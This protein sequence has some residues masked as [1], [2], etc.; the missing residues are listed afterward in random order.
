MTN[1]ND[2]NQ[3]YK[4]DLTHIY[5]NW[6]EWD[7]DLLKLKEL[8]AEVPKYEGLISQNSNNFIKFIA[9]EESVARLLDKVYLYPYLQRDLDSTNEKASVKLQEIESIYANYSIASSWIT[10][11]ILTIPEETMKKWIDENSEL[12]PNR[13]P[14][15]EVYRLQEH[16]LTADKEKLLSYFGQYLGVPSD[17]YS[18]LS[19][20]DIK[21]NEIELKDGS[22][23]TVTNGVYSKIVSTNRNQEDR[24]KAFE[25]L[26]NSFNINKNTYASIYKSILQRDFADAQSRNYTSSLQ[27]SLNPKNIPLDVYKTL[28]ES[29]R[30]NTAPLKRYIS[31]RKKALEI[32]DYHYYD[33]SINLIDYK[34]EFSYEEAKKTV[35]DSVKPLGDDY[36][37]GL[38]T[39]L[40]DGWLDVYETPNKRSGAYSL[41]IYDVHPY[42]LLNYN[43]TMD[44]VFTLAHELGH[45]MHSMLS[46]KNQPYPI[47][48][49]TIFVAEVASTFNERL[50]LDNM[51]KNTTDSKEKIALIEQAIGGIVGT[52]YIQTL[53][54]DYEYEAHKIVENGGAITPE[55]LNKIME[56]LFKDYFGSDLAMDDLQ[57]IIWARIPHFFNSPYYVYQYATSFAS[58]ANLYDRV[59]NNKYSED[60]KNI[61]KNEYLTLLK[62]GGNDHPMN[63]LKKA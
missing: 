11:E 17:I 16:V 51:L 59:T 52:F 14:L 24:K 55:V 50:L 38:S 32:T 39:A 9:L 12:Q 49:Y 35:L 36:S 48:S 33:N 42:M 60:E 27:K 8:M 31:L 29:T 30:E 10:P 37:K 20:S 6:N 61:A 1:N 44:A 3:Q 2:I 23:A 56:N 47:S 21:W 41:N 45:T 13:F 40:S 7:K 63:Q 62:S 5:P 54:A 34:K 25:A 58:S 43:G 19:T 18:E 57:K 22:K 28:I 15:M 4:W 46:T 26:Y 53:F